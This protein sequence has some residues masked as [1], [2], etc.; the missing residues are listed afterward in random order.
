MDEAV[1]PVQMSNCCCVDDRQELGDNDNR[2]DVRGFAATRSPWIVDILGTKVRE[3]LAW[4]STDHHLRLRDLATSHRRDVALDRVILAKVGGIGRGSVQVEL[5]GQQRFEILGHK[6]AGHAPATGEK[7]DEC[8]QGS[9]GKGLVRQSGV[10]RGSEPNITRGG[11]NRRWYRRRLALARA[12]RRGQ[13]SNPSPRV[14]ASVRGLARHS[15]QAC[16]A[17]SRCWLQVSGRG[18]GTGA[19]NSRQQTLQPASS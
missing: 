2:D 12:P 1:A 15:V 18:V 14:H 7:V 6:T 3:P 19:R 17:R 5:D 16:D 8:A 13:R 9:N 10:A 4:R 11:Q